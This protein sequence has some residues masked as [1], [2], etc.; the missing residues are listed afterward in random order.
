MTDIEH[1]V[2]PQEPRPDRLSAGSKKRD[3]GATLEVPSKKVRMNEAATAEIK[4]SMETASNETG[5]S[6]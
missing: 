2:G 4:S 6:P 3:A 1:M 5:T